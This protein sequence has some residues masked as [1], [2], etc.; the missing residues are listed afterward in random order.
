MIHEVETEDLSRINDLGNLEN[1]EIDYEI[2]NNRV[3][4]SNPVVLFALNIYLNGR[5]SIQY[6]QIEAGF[7]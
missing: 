3:L 4:C 6:A 2:E 7:F 1:W 5:E